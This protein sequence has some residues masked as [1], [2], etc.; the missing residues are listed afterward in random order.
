MDMFEMLVKGRLLGNEGEGGKKYRVYFYNGDTLL[1]TVKNVP[2]GGSAEYTGET[3]TKTGVTYPEDYTFTGWDPLPEN[4]VADTYCYAQFSS[5]EITES[6][7]EIFAAIA[8]GTYKT[9]YSIGD[10]KALDLGDEGL[11]NMQIAAFDADELADGSGKAS[12]TWV[13][14]ELLNTK[15]RMATSGSNSAV[16]GFP[17]SEMRTYLRGTILPLFP[18]EVRVGIKNVKKYSAAYN[19]LDQLTNRDGS[20][21]NIWLLS[22]REIDMLNRESNGP[23][24]SE[25][26]YDAASRIKKRTVDEN[27]SA[28]WTRSASS[29]NQYYSVST[30]GINQ[31]PFYGNTSSLGVAFGFCT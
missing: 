26:F 5:P 7:E 1:Q 14:R 30:S 20:T 17:K 13:T 16:D 29:K 12:I 28:W 22:T 15:H 2:E 19:S 11:I 25:I 23:K 18:R 8:D 4:I 24:Y 3:P 10:Y 31:S 27:A 21:E 6:W 9:R